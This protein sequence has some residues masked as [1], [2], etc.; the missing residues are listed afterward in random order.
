MRA[1][2]QASPDVIQ[3]L[4]ADCRE[5][6]GMAAKRV[7]G[8]VQLMEVCGTHSHVIARAGL[9]RL[10]G[11]QVRLVSGPGCPV[12]VTAP[13]QIDL[14][15]TLAERPNTVLATFGDMVRVPGS[16]GSL[17]EVRARGGRIKVVYSPME[18]LEIARSA[19]HTEFVMAAVGFETTAPTVACMVRE[20]RRLGLCNVTILCA[21]KLVPPAL[22][23]LLEARDVSLHGFIC[24][25]H[26]SVVIGSKAYQQ[27]LDK[28]HVPCVVAGFEPADVLWAVR[29]LLQQIADGEAR[30]ENAYSRAV[31]PDGNRRAVEVMYSVFDVDEALWRGLGAIPRSGLKLKD[32]WS[33]FDAVKRF[34]LVTPAVQEHPTCHCGEI[35]R[36]ALL[37]RE[38]VAFGKACTPARPLGPCMV[39]S[40]GACAAEYRYRVA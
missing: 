35:L 30:V 36:G 37:P 34:G 14:C 33:E 8:C 40:E 22:C 7:G 3:R 9:Q 19:P 2:P 13:G 6:A 32:E 28:Y 12:C 5:L 4:A 18:V 1:L 26:V 27:I 10:L 15:L 29:M 25:G 21:H 31:S 38:C 16:Q 24:P 39:S 17:A 20:A 11:K 23:A